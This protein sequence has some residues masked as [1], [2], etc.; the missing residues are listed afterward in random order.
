MRKLSQRIRRFVIWTQSPEG[1]TFRRTISGISIFVAISLL[2][3]A[4]QRVPEWQVKRAHVQPTVTQP[5]KPT[6]PADIAALQNEMRKTLIQIVGGIFAIIALYYTWRRVKVA[7]QGHITDRYTKAIEQLGALTADGKP[8]IEVR[9]GA[10]YALERIAQDSARDHWTIMEVLTAYVRQNAPAPAEK[11]SKEENNK[12]IAKGPPTEIQ[13]ILTVLGR[14]KGDRKRERE[15][16][17]LD[18]RKSDLRG[19]DLDGA[20]MGPAIFNHAHL[21]GVHLD[22]AHL[23]GAAFVEAH[24][25]GA[26]FFRAHGEG[27]SFKVAHLEGAYLNEAHLEGAYLNEA[28]LEGASFSWAHLEGASFY[29]AHLEGASF[30]GARLERA[31]FVEARLEG[32]DF[33]LATGLTSE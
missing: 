31:V 27:A 17:Q 14:R 13:A 16:Q 28:H 32:A 8:N 4:V 15:D 26:L 3:V 20:Q 2:L 9:L 1:R 18:L 21:E 24:L 10:I 12:A 5:E 6:T 33:R 30:F 29:E 7:E 11:P 25:E 23:E 19:A 22:E